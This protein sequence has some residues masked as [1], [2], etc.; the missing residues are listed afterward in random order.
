MLT[1]L[2]Q[3]AHVNFS[4]QSILFKGKIGPG[5]RKDR[6]RQIVATVFLAIFLFFGL[7]L[8]FFGNCGRFSMFFRGL[9]PA[10]SRFCG[11]FFVFCI[12]LRPFLFAVNLDLSS[13]AGT[14]LLNEPVKPGLWGQALA[15]GHLQFYFFLIRVDL[16]SFVVFYLRLRLRCAVSFVVFFRFRFP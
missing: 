15:L 1:L 9:G 5:N 8:S 14:D 12:L 6:A 4:C 2:R 16:C 13:F 7:F 11:F 3:Y 10:F